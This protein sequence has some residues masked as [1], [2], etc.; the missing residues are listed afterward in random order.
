M[1]DLIWLGLL[2]VGLAVAAATGR[3]DQVTEAVMSS[4][5]VAVETVIGFL[6][7]TSLWLGVMKIAEEAGLVAALARWLEP[8]LR[9]LFPGIP[10]G[11]PALGAVVMSIS[12]NILGVGPAATPLGLKAMQELQRINPHKHAASDA[13]VTFLAM[14]TS[15]I[16]LIPATVIAVRAAAG[17][18][19]PAEIVGPTL[20]ASTVATCVALLADRLL[21]PL[22]PVPPPPPGREEPAGPLQEPPAA[23]GH[24]PEA[25]AG[26]AGTGAVPAGHRPPGTAA[27]DAREQDPASEPPR[28]RGSRPARPRATPSGRRAG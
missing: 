10:A 21:R 23:P 4:S 25:A 14:T 16:T 24:G 13:M 27:P 7:I 20:V 28:R 15:G 18:A 5:Q 2:V 8:L 11:D 22:A 17:S 19:H 12:A 26:R 1:I 6:G 3:V 9:R